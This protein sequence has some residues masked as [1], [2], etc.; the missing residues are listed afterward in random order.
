MERADLERLRELKR[1]SATLDEKL[2]RLYEQATRTTALLDGL[3]KGS[4][5]R[6]KIEDSI[7]KIES[8]I[9]ETRADIFELVL[10]EGRF[11]ESMSVLP[12]MERR[13]LTMRYLDGDGYQRIANDLGR[14]IDH[15]FKLHRRGLKKILSEDS[16]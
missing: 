9:E 2:Q 13:V 4:T 5:M 14:S 11:E 1:E 15:I 3:P 8:A 7:V 16:K 10:L 12:M 6:S